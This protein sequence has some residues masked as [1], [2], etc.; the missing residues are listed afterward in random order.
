M[1]PMQPMQS[2]QCQYSAQ[3]HI[4]CNPR[5]GMGEQEGRNPHTDALTSAIE[6]FVLRVNRIQGYKEKKEDCYMADSDGG[7]GWIRMVGGMEARENGG[8]NSYDRYGRK[9]YKSN[10]EQ[11]AVNNNN[12]MMIKYE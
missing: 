10:V 5:M 6:H 3:G 1:Q 12:K 9:I 11:C 2:M 4:I 8:L 7:F